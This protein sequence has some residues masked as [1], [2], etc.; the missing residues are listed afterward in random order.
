M[1][2]PSLT[3][4]EITVL[5]LVAQGMTA[6]IIAHKIHVA[7]R[8]VHF[9]FGCIKT[10]LGASTMEEVMYIAGRD[11]LLGEYLPNEEA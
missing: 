9:F 11:N 2:S 8:T 10:K 4:R 1:N 7:Q 6:K 3:P 5:R